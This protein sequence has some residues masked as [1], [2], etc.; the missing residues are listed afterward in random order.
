MKTIE[1]KGRKA[2]EL[3]IV[4]AFLVYVWCVCGVSEIPKDRC[5]LPF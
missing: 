5:I 4:I 2:L 1:Y 3:S